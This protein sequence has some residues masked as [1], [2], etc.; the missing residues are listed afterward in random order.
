MWY[1]IPAIRLANGVLQ[2]DQRQKILIFPSTLQ[3]SFGG[4]EPYDMQ[5][6]WGFME[7]FGETSGMASHF[8]HADESH[9]TITGWMEDAT[10]F[11]SVRCL[12]KCYQVVYFS[13]VFS[14]E[15]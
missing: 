5:S 15:L 14:N 4:A 3:W 10:Q 13:F 8:F 12:L 6:R 1:S 11:D 7:G 9:E 2:A